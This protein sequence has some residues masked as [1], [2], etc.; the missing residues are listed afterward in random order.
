MGDGHAMKAWDPINEQAAFPS[1]HACVGGWVHACVGVHAC[2]C[3]GACMCVRVC[4]GVNRTKVC[5]FD[6]SGEQWYGRGVLH[7]RVGWVNT[8]V[9]LSGWG[10]CCHVMLCD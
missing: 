8:H 1:L 6:V 2:A 7:E 9:M 5:M 10:L 3:V 4:V